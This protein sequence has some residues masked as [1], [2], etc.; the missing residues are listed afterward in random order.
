[1]SEAPKPAKTE[2]ISV[3]LYDQETCDMMTDTEAETLWRLHQRHG[4]A[5]DAVC[6]ELT[7]I[8]G[9]DKAGLSDKQRD[10]IVEEAGFLTDEFDEADTAGRHPRDDTQLMCCLRRYHDLGLEI[11]NIRDDI[12]SR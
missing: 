11:M 6:D 4:E 10:A 3:G 7:S 1:M 9:Y 5:F 12:R 8:D 2:L